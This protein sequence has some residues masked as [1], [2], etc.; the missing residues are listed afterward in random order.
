MSAKTPAVLRGKTLIMGKTPLTATIRYNLLNPGGYHTVQGSIGQGQPEILNPILEQDQLI[1][2]KSGTVQQGKF[3][4]VLTESRV[5]GTMQLQYENFKIDMLSKP[6]GDPDKKPRQSLG[7]KILSV[8]ANKAVLNT[9]NM[10]G[11]NGYKEG[12]INTPHRKNRSVITFWIDGLTSGIRST[13]GL[14]SKVPD[15]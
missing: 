6:K 10:P 15:K 14:S 7:K 2:V 1:R 12:Q 11:I 8:F 4:M 5:Q 9:D 13:V 3:N